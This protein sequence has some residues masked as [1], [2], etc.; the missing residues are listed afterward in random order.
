[1]A[2]HGSYIVNILDYVIRGDHEKA[3]QYCKDAKKE[4]EFLKTSVNITDRKRLDCLSQFI[5]D[6]HCG[7]KIGITTDT[8]LAKTAVESYYQEESRKTNQPAVNNSMRQVPNQ[9]AVNNSMR[10]VPNQPAVNNS[11]RQ[12]PNQPAVNNSM[13]QVPNQPPVN[14]TMEQVP[15]Q[16]AVNNTMRQVPNQPA[17]NNTMR[18]VPNQPAVN[19]TMRQ[20]PNQSDVN[21]TMR[22]NSGTSAV[23]TN[24]AQSTNQNTVNNSLVQDDVSRRNDDGVTSQQLDVERGFR[25]VAQAFG[26]LFDEEWASAFE[27][28]HDDISER[29][30]VQILLEV[31]QKAYEFNKVERDRQL[32][33]AERIAKTI[34]AGQGYVQKSADDPTN[35]KDTLISFLYENALYALPNLQ[36]KFQTTEMEKMNKKWAEH[37]KKSSIR[38][39]IKADF[40][41]YIDKCVQLTWLICIEDPPIHMAYGKRN[42]ALDMQFY[43]PYTKQGKYIDYIAWPALQH[44]DMK[45][46]VLLK[47]R[48]QGKDKQN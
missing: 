14:N 34:V 18:Q 17:V 10:Q 37:L 13:R 46:S 47:G 23:N 33:E 30:K 26:V 39:Q 36:K 1:M 19:N 6:I 16:P 48:A 5:E 42:D 11:M 32:A 45:G 27:E 28:L 38:F 7:K 22:L 35:E 2:K 25:A 12:V 20:V 40:K 15:N 43:K 4:L 3:V 29:E 41:T 21:N 31:V 9:P 24:M 44:K 8:N